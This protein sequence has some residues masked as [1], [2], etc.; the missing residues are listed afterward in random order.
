MYT[1]KIKG[2]ENINQYEEL[3]KVFLPANMYVLSEE[4]AV[5]DEN[6]AVFTFEGDKDALKRNIYRYLSEATGKSPK[7]G[8]LTGIR[9]VK[10]AGELSDRLGCEEAAKK[11]MEDYL[12]HPQKVSLVM[13]ILDYQ[14]RL[15]GRP[16]KDSISIYM[17]IP[18]CPTRCLYCSFTSNQVKK[19]E[20]DRYLQALYKEIDYCAERIR[21]GSYNA[22]S[23]YIGGGTPT[24]LDEYQLEQLLDRICSSFDV[25]TM[26]E[27]TVEAGRP[28]TIT[29]EKLRLM[30]KYGVGRISINPQSMKQET[31]DI[32]G[33]AHTV[34]ETEA[35]FEMARD[36]GFDC[37]NAD[38]IA[39][40]PQEETDDFSRSLNRM[41]AMG[42]E[43]I[44]VHTLA[45]KKASRLMEL[46]S[47]FN[48][49]REDICGSML[50][51]AHEALKKSGY[52][53]Y[54]LYRQK[55][56][57]G[58]TEN[59][60]F[61]RKDLISPYNV[62]IMEEAQS[63]LALGAGGISK[64]Y[65]PDENRLERVVNVSNYEIYIDRID[66]MILRKE[67]NFWR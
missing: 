30:K 38:L 14:R 34:R 24:S 63:I 40:L 62:R 26:R 23:L 61:C 18:F 44:T 60:G 35:A 7:W 53:P 67:N 5:G 4:E 13:D 41:I 28:D 52:E 25:R 29:P 1:F 51:Y 31:L 9:P 66:E 16:H 36:A 11:L 10:L 19:P 22:E 55:H 15:L 59:V 58:N 42:A 57:S 64:V 50:E 3:I 54:Y 8:I 20:I 17:G 37:I 27:F 6:A 45:V 21:C 49:K 39:G 12:I 56:T 65:Y 2:V 47:D 48:Y 46:D 43:N 32:I 33:R